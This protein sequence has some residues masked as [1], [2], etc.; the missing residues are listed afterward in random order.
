MRLIHPDSAHAVDVAADTA[1]LYRSQGWVAAAPAAK[2]A[3]AA[4][5]DSLEDED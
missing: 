3:A 2:K 1:D 4:A 5:A